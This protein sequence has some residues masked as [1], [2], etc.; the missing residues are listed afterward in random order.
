MLPNIVLLDL[1]RTIIGNSHDLADVLDQAEQL[2]RFAHFLRTPVDRAGILHRVDKLVE[3]ALENGLLRPYFH[4]W[5]EFIHGSPVPTLVYV[6]SAGAKHYVHQFVESVER[7]VGIPFAR[8]IF[9]RDDTAYHLKSVRTIFDD[10]VAGLVRKGKVP[11]KAR[12]ELWQKHFLFIDDNAFTTYDTADKTIYPLPFVKCPPYNVYYPCDIYAEITPD[13]LQQSM[14]NNKP[15][16]G[17]SSFI[18]PYIKR[19]TKAKQSVQGKELGNLMAERAAFGLKL[20]KD[21][22]KYNAKYDGDTFWKQATDWLRRIYASQEPWLSPA[23]IKALNTAVEPPTK[24]KRTKGNK[25]R[26]T[27]KRTKAKRSA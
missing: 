19:K 18:P 9:T 11:A 16:T 24:R 1:D 3:K 14:R 12:D 20:A 2:V 27:G 6:Y 5:M 13:H 25:K 10:I 26:N 22:V 17:S 21:G 8:P 15:L 7:V 23:K 4:D